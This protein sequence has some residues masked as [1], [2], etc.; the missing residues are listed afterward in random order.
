MQIRTNTRL[1]RRLFLD[2]NTELL[3]QQ[4][5][6]FQP[7]LS[8]RKTAASLEEFDAD[9]ERLISRVFG[10]SSE[11]LQAYKYAT[12]GEAASL[13]NLPEEAQESGAQNLEQESLQQ[14]KRILESCLS[15]L[16]GIRNTRMI[17]GQVANYMSTEVRSV[18]INATLKEVG[19]LL[20]KWK[21]GSLLVDD[22]RQYVGIVT[23]TDLSRK[24]AARGL[25]PS[26]TTVNRCMTKPI[27]TI[28]DSEPMTAAVNLMKNNAVRHLAVT[29]DGTIMGVLSVADI[30]RYYADL[31]PTLC[32]LAGLTSEGEETQ[33]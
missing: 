5:F 11:L 7:F 9:T 20:K 24:G 28:E 3:R 8:R 26:A 19:N 17:A 33:G 30:L 12:L 27:I 23:D 10:E 15:T 29:V 22:G 16:E 31:V 2:R 18:H 32:D 25:D 4:L 1:A 21:V 14:R 13:V 6:R